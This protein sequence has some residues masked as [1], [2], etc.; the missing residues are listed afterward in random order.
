MSIKSMNNFLFLEMNILL[1]FILRIANQNDTIERLHRT[2]AETEEVG[3]E[4]I[5]ELQSN[6]EKIESSREKAKEVGTMADSARNM[7]RRM[8]KREWT[9]GFF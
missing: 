6:R 1:A 2:I 9:L 7:I 5:K 8:T 4:T 3:T